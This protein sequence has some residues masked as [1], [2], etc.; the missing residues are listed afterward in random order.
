MMKQ[1]R[2]YYISIE[3]D[4]QM[5]EFSFDELIVDSI[6]SYEDYIFNSGDD[7]LSASIRY[8]EDSEPIMEDGLAERTI[9]WLVLGK[10]LIKHSDKI[11]KS[12]YRELREIIRL[13]DHE[14][15]KKELTEDE[16]LRLSKMKNEV[17]EGIEKLK[18]VSGTYLMDGKE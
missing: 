12:V 3:G 16:L 7:P 17:E 9:I 6:E 1:E 10:M 11:F 4:E 8:Y 18:R 5:K 14:K 15:L 13:F 2:V